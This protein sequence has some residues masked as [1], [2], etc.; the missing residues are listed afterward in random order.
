MVRLVVFVCVHGLCWCMV[1]V[2]GAIGAVLVKL[3]LDFVLRLKCQLNV[4][5]GVASVSFVEI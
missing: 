3:Q 2:G 4:V 1:L 5:D